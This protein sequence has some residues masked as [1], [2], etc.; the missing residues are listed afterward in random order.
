MIF[1][2]TLLLTVFSRR[3]PAIDVASLPVAPENMFSLGL[4]FGIGQYQ[5]KIGFS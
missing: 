5:L 3:V 4:D 2:S 1:L